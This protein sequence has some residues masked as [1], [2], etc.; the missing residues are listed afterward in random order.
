MGFLYVVRGRTLF[1]INLRVTI[2]GDER[3][4]QRKARKGTR[5][6]RDGDGKD[7]DRCAAP[8]WNRRAERAKD[9]YATRTAF[10]ANL[11]PLRPWRDLCD[12]CAKSSTS[13][14]AR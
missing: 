14:L 11:S 2:R 1:G 4:I 5:E 12:L 13:L 9:A 3:T 6:G 7:L 8:K 10:R